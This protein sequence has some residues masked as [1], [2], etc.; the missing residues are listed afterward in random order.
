[1][2]LSCRVCA[3]PRPLV[4]PTDDTRLCRRCSR[5]RHPFSR[6]RLWVLLNAAICRAFEARLEATIALQRLSMAS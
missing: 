5:M 4:T 6:V 2:Y 1:M 3:E